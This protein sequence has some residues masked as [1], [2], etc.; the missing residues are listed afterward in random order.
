MKRRRT[1]GFTLSMPNVGSWNGKWSGAGRCY[2]IVRS[3]PISKAD[4]I[5]SK[6]GFYYRWDDGWGASIRAEELNSL[7][8]RRLRAKSVGFCG[9]DWMVNSIE[10][11]CA[12]YA[13]HE[14]PEVLEAK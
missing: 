10:K 7:A 1:I 4:E 5:L 11:Y 12:I 14:L 9:Y 2:A 8:A 6:G 3:Y 13:D